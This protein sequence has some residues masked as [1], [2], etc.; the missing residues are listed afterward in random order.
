[1]VGHSYAGMLITELGSHPSVKA[2]AYVAAFLPDVGESAGGLQSKTPPAGN[3]V[4]PVGDGFLQIK[5][6]AFPNDFAADVPKPL[7]HFMAISQVPI[8]GE[9][10]GAKVTVAAWKD[11]PSYAVIPKQ[12]RSINPELHRFMT[13]RAHSQT[14]E[15]SGS[16]AIFLSHPTEVAKLIERAAR[17]VK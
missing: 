10:F 13:S 11:K 4:E 17:A 12:D 15:L 1:M 7:A 9:I 14:I 8:A 2:L 16:H 6:D 5:S 3:S